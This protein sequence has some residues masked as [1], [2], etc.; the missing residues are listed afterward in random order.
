MSSF[1]FLLLNLFTMSKL[2]LMLLEEVGILFSIIL[3]RNVEKLNNVLSVDETITLNG[4]QILYTFR[5]PY[6]LSSKPSLVL[7]EWYVKS[8]IN[9]KSFHLA[10]IFFKPFVIILIGNFLTT[11]YIE[12]WNISF[13][14][15]M[16]LFLFG[17]T[18][19]F[20]LLAFVRMIFLLSFR[21]WKADYFK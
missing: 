8:V 21:N 13:I 15:V 17:A 1:S 3:C 7:S 5:T 16:Y 19:I 10:R 20:P 2:F 4:C 14:L 9:F 12:S 18:V 6:T 11:E